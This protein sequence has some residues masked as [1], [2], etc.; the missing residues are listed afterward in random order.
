VEP[1]WSSSDKQVHAV[2]TLLTCA[3]F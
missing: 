2:G 3:C 1:N